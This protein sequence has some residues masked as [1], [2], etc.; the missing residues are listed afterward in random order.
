MKLPPDKLPAFLSM[1]AVLM[2]PGLL[3]AAEEAREEIGRLL[4][5]ARQA[6][7]SLEAYTGRTLK[8]ERFGREL[9]TQEFIFKFQRPFHVYIRYI[10]PCEGR[11]AIF[12]KGKNRNRIKVHKGC[13]PD[14]TTN[15]QPTGKLA[16]KDNHHPIY[17]FGLGYLTELAAMSFNT[18][19]E[20]DEG[21]FAPPEQTRLHGRPTWRIQANF[22]MAGHQIIS[23]E[24]TS[25]ADIAAQTN[26]DAYV[27]FHSN[28]GLKRL[29]E[30]E[31]GTRIFIP[32]YYG[33]RA[34][35]HLDRETLLPLK[36]SIWDWNDELYEEYEFRDLNLNPVLNDRDFDADNPDYDF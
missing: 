3:P 4:Q 11:E 13:F 14:I 26:R 34:E 2:F 10:Q 15:I 31:P 12:V 30:L 22:P 1:L 24:D 21:W 18:A 20:N 28:P 35:I 8:R 5:Q 29:D 9:K 23:E 27:L 17:H 36:I 32:R 7:A 19:M 6:V 16:L 25:L 33:K